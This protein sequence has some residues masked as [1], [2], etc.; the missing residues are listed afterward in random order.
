M[1]IKTTRAMLQNIQWAFSNIVTPWNFGEMGMEIIKGDKIR[2]SAHVE[3]P[4]WV[5]QHGNLPG[6]RY[7]DKHTD[8]MRNSLRYSYKSLYLNF[9]E[10]RIQHQCEAQLN[11]GTVPQVPIL[12]TILENNSHLIQP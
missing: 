2:A 11:R 5:R 7:I 10:I 12:S 1:A 6:T 3:P 4:H 9:R 8:N